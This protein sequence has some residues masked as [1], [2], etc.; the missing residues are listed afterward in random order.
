MEFMDIFSA[1]CCPFQKEHKP[2]PPVRLWLPV[3]EM[4]GFV[5]TGVLCASSN[6]QPV[7]VSKEYSLV[8]PKNLSLFLFLFFLTDVQFIFLAAAANG[9]IVVVAME[10]PTHRNGVFLTC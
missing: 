8:S 6:N 10:W 2:I 9:G 4:C 7:Q 1:F 5:T 3:K